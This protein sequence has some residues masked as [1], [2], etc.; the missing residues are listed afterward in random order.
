[1]KEELRKKIDEVVASIV[2]RQLEETLMEQAFALAD[3]PEEKKEA[4]AYLKEAIAM[5]KK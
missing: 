1:M 3:T 2:N 5:Q 4:G